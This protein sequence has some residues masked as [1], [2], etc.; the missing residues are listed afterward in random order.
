MGTSG[1]AGLGRLGGFFPWETLHV[2]G[3]SE[4]GKEIKRRR[5]RRKKLAQL[6]K[7][8]EKANVSEKGVIAA[9]LRRLTPGAEVLIDRYELRELDR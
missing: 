1:A 6:N 9:K 4:R 3:I 5:Q 8:L 7:R 2:A